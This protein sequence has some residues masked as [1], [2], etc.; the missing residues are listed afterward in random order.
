MYRGSCLADACNPNGR[1][2]NAVSA[3]RS[4]HLPAGCAIT[5]TSIV[6]NAKFREVLVP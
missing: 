4:I 5:F 1:P 3:C 6:A 2:I